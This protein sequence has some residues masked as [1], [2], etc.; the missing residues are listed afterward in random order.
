MEKNLTTGSVFK[1]ILI[2]SL[3]YLL[4]YFLQ[5]LYGM[6]DLFII[7]QFEGVASTTAVSIGSQVM[8]MLTV[9]IV[10]LAMGSTVSI[11]QAV[12][13]GDRKKAAS[14]I[15]N[16]VTLFMC[17]SVVL[18]VALLI[19]VRPVVNIMSTPEAAVSGTI[20]YLT[21]CFIGIPFITAY[22]IISSIFRGLGDS[23]SPMYFIA[24]ACVANIA[25]DYLFMGAL[26]LGPSGAAL[27]TT[28]SQAVSVIIALVVIRRHSGALAVKK[29]DFRPARPVMAKLLRI[30][31]PI[32]MQDGLIQI[33]FI[34]ITVIANRRGL[35]D[36]AAVGIVEKI[37][38]F[39]F[40]VPSS[41][42]STVSALG[43]QNIGA[44]KPER[45]RLTLR[46]A[47][48]I[49]ICFG[50]CMVILMQFAA[51][52]V[53]SLFTDSGQSDGAEVIRL[54]GQYMRGYVWDCIFAGVHFSFSGYFCACGRS[55]LSFLHNI[56]AILLV[57]V[58][59]VYLTSLYFPDTLFPMGLATSMGSL[60]SV[61]IC[62]IAYTVI[63]SG[64]KSS[65]SGNHI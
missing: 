53:V 36:A 15:G 30:G 58:P 50:A 64:K 60:L 63:L 37:I 12:G 39:L 48:C 46:Y 40:L 19:F 24:V 3:P 65:F 32:A 42:L 57:R 18:T 54:G 23:K 11:G 8:H 41:M 14:G 55:G 2:F 38:S 56:S 22:N 61:I 6:A 1:N 47:A 20:E 10:G 16:T 33:A 35:N 43:A 59:G 45:A 21:I 51:E 26:H 49:A 27:G 62:V 17:L 44:G 5:T 34:I 25:L 28:L 9:M 7:G 31:V 4:S 29:S 13:A 52:P